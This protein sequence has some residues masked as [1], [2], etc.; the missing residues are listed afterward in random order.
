MD[1]DGDEGLGIGMGE[2]VASPFAP[3][4]AAG[5]AGAPVLELGLAEPGTDIGADMVL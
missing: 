3:A 5:A 4:L 1:E 2:G